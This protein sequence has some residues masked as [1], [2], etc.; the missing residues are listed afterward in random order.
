MP[1]FEESLP[2]NRIWIGWPEPIGVVSA[3]D[4]LND[5]ITGVML[6]GSGVT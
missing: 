2:D 3:A 5:S 1:S 4:A 6:R